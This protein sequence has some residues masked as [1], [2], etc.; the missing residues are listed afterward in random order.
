MV[1]LLGVALVET[2]CRRHLPELLRALLEPGRVI[3]EALRFIVQLLRHLLIR[4]ADL[5]QLVRPLVLHPDLLGE[6]LAHV[7]RVDRRGEGENRGGEQGELKGSAH[8]FSDEV[9]EGLVVTRYRC[10][11]I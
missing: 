8:V 4:L 2:L 6:G 10:E 11:P 3:D 1:L 5:L 7:L 9:A